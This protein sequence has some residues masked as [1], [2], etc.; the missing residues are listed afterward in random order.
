[1]L[2]GYVVGALLLMACRGQPGWRLP[3]TTDSETTERR[4]P[5]PLN[6]WTARRRLDNDKQQHHL[7]PRAPGDPDVTGGRACHGGAWA[8][9]PGQLRRDPRRSGVR[10]GPRIPVHPGMHRERHHAEA[11][12]ATPAA[13]CPTAAAA[14][15]AAFAALLYAWVGWGRKREKE[16]IERGGM[17]E[18]VPLVCMTYGPGLTCSGH[19]RTRRTQRRSGLCPLGT[20]IWH[21]FEPEMGPN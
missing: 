19:N 3:N 7:A 11:A 18:W 5:A 4:R 15:P 2:V 6:G 20:Q 8:P 17:G 21:K 14:A 9:P 1:M 10:S 16:E 13:S 12:S